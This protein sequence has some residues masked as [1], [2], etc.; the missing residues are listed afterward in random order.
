[1]KNGRA[2]TLQENYVIGKSLNFLQNH[3]SAKAF[4]PAATKLNSSKES[5]GGKNQQQNST[6]L[7]GVTQQGFSWLLQFGIPPITAVRIYLNAGSVACG[8]WKIRI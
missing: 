6:A 8:R 2:L 1:M 5:R 3:F 7:T 4:H